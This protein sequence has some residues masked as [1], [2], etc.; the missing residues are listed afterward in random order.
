M[1]CD[2]GTSAAAAAAATTVAAA[3]RPLVDAEVVAHAFVPVARLQHGAGGGEI[4]LLAQRP[5]YHEQHAIKVGDI[6]RG[7]MLFRTVQIAGG[8]TQKRPVCKTK[9]GGRQLKP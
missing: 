7:L 9:K 1:D 6:T 5:L 3:A 8:E 4:L 2:R